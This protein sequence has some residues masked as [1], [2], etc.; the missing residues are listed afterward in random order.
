M[1]NTK[2]YWKM[3]TAIVMM[4]V[5]ALLFVACDGECLIKQK[6]EIGK[7]T[8]G[9]V[10]SK[11]GGFNPDK[12]LML[13]EFNVGE[14]YY[15][16][17]DFSI[18]TTTVGL[19]FKTNEITLKIK[20]ENMDFL[21]GWIQEA[22]TNNASERTNFN[23]EATNAKEVK[24]T[25]SVPREAKKTAQKRVVIRLIPNK[26]KDNVVK[27]VFE[28]K[29]VEIQG[30]GRDGYIKDIYAMPVQIETPQVSVDPTTGVASWD[31][32]E[33]ADYYKLIVD[34]VFVKNIIPDNNISVGKEI[35]LVLSEYGYTNGESIRIVAVSNNDEYY[36]ESNRS[37]PVSVNL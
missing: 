15:M 23:G 9:F 6:V 28:G 26:L 12:T 7:P 1:R 24:A 27:V 29:N 32:V 2:K 17:I 16:V 25:F 37:E 8:Y 34:D 35:L 14:T 18:T 5:L 33:H 4:I 30:D 22:D 19:G 36:P 20:F 3:V 11:D 31:H 13:T 10:Q 21:N